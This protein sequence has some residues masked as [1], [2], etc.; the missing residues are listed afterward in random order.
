MLKITS[1]GLYLSQEDSNAKIINETL[2]QLG[3][4]QLTEAEI[5]SLYWLCSCELV[6][7]K[8][9]MKVFEKALAHERE[10]LQDLQAV[11]R[12]RKGARHPQ[13]KIDLIRTR[14]EANK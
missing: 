11:E 13:E 7:V 2:S 12:G 14:A 9:I 6:H 10:Y 5:S 1:E 3:N 8:N 4:I